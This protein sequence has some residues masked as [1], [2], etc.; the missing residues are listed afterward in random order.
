MQSYRFA[1]WQCTNSGVR[2]RSVLARDLRS[3]S[4]ASTLLRMN[5]YR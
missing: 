3:E 1:F 4:R 5:G 2:R